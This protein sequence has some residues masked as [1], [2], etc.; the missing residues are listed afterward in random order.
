MPTSRFTVISPQEVYVG[1]IDSDDYETAEFDIY[2]EKSSSKNLMLP[3]H[4]EYMDA[5][6]KPYSKD[7]EVALVLYSKEELKKLGFV[8]KSN[9]L[10]GISIVLA[11]IGIGFYI[12]RRLKNKNNKKK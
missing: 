4:L 3:L 2:V 10:I 11:S 7:I 12:R 5:N 8:Q 9:P 1:N 6:N